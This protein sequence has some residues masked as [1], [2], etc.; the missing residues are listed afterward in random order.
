MSK[1]ESSAVVSIFIIE[2]K[3]VDDGIQW[4]HY[5]AIC[6]SPNINSQVQSSCLFIIVSRIKNSASTIELTI[7]IITANSKLR[8]AGV[9]FIIYVPREL[10]R[11]I[12]NA[13]RQ[14]A[15]IACKIKTQ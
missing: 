9:Q 5:A 2:P 15:V 1:K 11:I 7:L 3:A 13:C 8:V 10:L 6:L 14:S 12:Q 4:R